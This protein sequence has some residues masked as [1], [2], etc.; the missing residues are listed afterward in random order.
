MGG[1]QQRAPALYTCQ[2]LPLPLFL[3]DPPSPSVIAHGPDG[4]DLA[5]GPD[6][7]LLS[8]PDHSDQWGLL[9]CSPLG[10]LLRTFAAPI[11]HETLFSL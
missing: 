6:P 1:T 8:T 11:G 2:V 5:P 9:A 4:I 7:C 10:T 3:W